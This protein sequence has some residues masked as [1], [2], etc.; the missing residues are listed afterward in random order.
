MTGQAVTYTATVSPVPDGGTVAFTDG[1][2]RSAGA[3]PGGEQQHRQA[4][5]QVTYASAGAHSI[6]A[7]YAGDTAFA[8]STSAALTQ[9]VN[10]AATATTIGSVG[11]SLGGRAGGD[12]HRHGQAARRGRD[13]DRHGDVHRRQHDA[14]HPDAERQRDSGDHHLGR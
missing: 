8:A 14:R 12:I 5:C 9:T 11:E 2:T 10:Q 6:T 7:A 4:T 13:T 1:S 3:A